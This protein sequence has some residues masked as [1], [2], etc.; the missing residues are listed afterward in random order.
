MEDGLT[1]LNNLAHRGACG[2]DPKTGDGGPADP[3]AAR[4]FQARSAEAQ[5]QYS[6]GRRIRRGHRARRAEKDERAF[7]MTTLEETIKEEGQVLLGW[8]DV[9]VV[10]SSIGPVA[11]SREPHL[12]QIFIGKG[13]S[14]KDQ[15]TLERKLLVIRKVAERWKVA[16]I[17][18]AHKNMFYICSLSS[19]TFVYKGQLMSE[20]LHPYFPDL[21]NPA[22][23]SSVGDGAFPL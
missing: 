4:V 9:P 18:F 3:A 13:V 15:P 5:H 22:M 20:Q 14:V 2:C 11:R 19:Q 21:A 7:C 12:K 23:E 8:R 17:R 6:V 10:S 1:I 16:G